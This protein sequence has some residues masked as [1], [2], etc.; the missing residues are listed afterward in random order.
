[1]PVQIGLEEL[2]SALFSRVDEV[3][4]EN[5]N[6]QSKFNIMFRALYKKGVFTDEDILESV[7]DEN[8][9]LLSLGLIK[10]MPDEKVLQAAANNIMLWIKGDVNEIKNSVEKFQQKLKEAEA[11]QNKPKIDVAPAA[12]LNELDRLGGRNNN[13]GGLII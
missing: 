9:I 3:T 2:L 8:K 1:M 5:Q 10:E 12:V 11:Q 4:L 13:H 6:Q 7:R